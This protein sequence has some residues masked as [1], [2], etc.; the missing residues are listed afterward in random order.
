MMTLTLVTD[1]KPIFSLHDGTRSKSLFKTLVPQSGT[2][3]RN[4][5]SPISLVKVNVCGQNVAGPNS[6]EVPMPIIS[7]FRLTLINTS[8]LL[9]NI[10]VLDEGMK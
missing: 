4:M 7:Q 10:L 3:A 8:Y 2:G 5:A 9:H 6:D 1:G